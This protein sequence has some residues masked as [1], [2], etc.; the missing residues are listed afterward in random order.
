MASLMQIN[1]GQPN[2]SAE[3]RTRTGFEG[4]SFAANGQR[5]ALQECE[6]GL[7]RMA[8]SHS[9]QYE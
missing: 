2:L 4:W 7:T 3:E 9:G 6:R 8:M 1:S 5:L